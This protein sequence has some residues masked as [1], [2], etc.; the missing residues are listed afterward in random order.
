MEN[1]NQENIKNENSFEQLEPFDLD[2]LEAQSELSKEQKVEIEQAHEQKEV[3]SRQEV[4]D[5][6]NRFEEN[7]RESSPLEYFEAQ[8][9]GHREDVYL[10]DYNASFASYDDQEGFTFRPNL[11]ESAQN[12]EESNTM[13]KSAKR[14]STLS[15]TSSQIGRALGHTLGFK[16]F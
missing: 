7:D 6:F 1:F 10:E 15:Q 14:S 12:L 4:L 9:E 16:A 11:A 5:A 3:K 2:A 8:A 13:R